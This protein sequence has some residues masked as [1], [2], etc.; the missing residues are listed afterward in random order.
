MIT[1]LAWCLAIPP[2]ISLTL[3][4][5]ECLL[6]LAREKPVSA[7]GGAPK[8]L[9]LMPAHNESATIAETLKRLKP[10]LQDQL[11]LLVVADNCS[12]DTADIAR[13]HGVDVIER[14]APDARG[15][16]Y[17]LAFGRDHLQKMPA[18]NRPECIIVFDADCE[19]DA[20]SMAILSEYCITRDVVV[21]AHYVLAADRQ[22]KPMVQISNFAFWM[23][24]VIRQRGGKRLGA[25]ALLTGTGMAFPWPLFAKLPLATSNIVEDLGLGIYL[26]HMGKAPV[27]LDQ[28]VVQSVA[29]S[30]QATLGQ[31]TRWEHGFIAMARQHGIK[32]LFEGMKRGNRKLFQL[33]LHLMVPPLAMLFAAAGAALIAIAALAFLSG[34]L[35]PFGAL[36]LSLTLAALAVVFAWY[37]GGRPWLSPGAFLKLP[38]YMLWKIPVFLRL[39]RG[40]NPGW[41]RTERPQDES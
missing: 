7:G 18:E 39:V 15:K 4:S 3:F 41:N 27:Y 24:N 23:K 37:L 8:T 19:S 2:I 9:L 31:R 11:G 28:A 26:T 10:I 1:F 21:Q 32:A 13:A 12:D 29:A 22:A 35:Y 30:E 5:L 20:R 6:G 14:I 38:F 17:A 34:N 25:A 36:L 40:D 16:G 33:G